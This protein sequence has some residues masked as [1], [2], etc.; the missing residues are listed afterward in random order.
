MKIFLSGVAVCWMLLVYSL[1]V[2]LGYEPATGYPPVATGSLWAVGLSIPVWI[3]TFF[4]SQRS[5]IA[6]VA[7]W[8][9]AL[10]L[11]SILYFMLAETWMFSLR[12]LVDGRAFTE[13]MTA[14]VYLPPL[15]LSVVVGILV[16]PEA[17]ML[18]DA[19]KTMEP[20][21]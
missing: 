16:W 20:T 11:V 6:V 10:A 7:R 17:R 2:A 3:A 9:S 8:P 18:L 19:N 13:P 21:R 12:P 5:T 1:H 14:I 4:H 15:L